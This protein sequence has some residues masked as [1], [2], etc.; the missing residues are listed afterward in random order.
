MASNE[1]NLFAYQ[2]LHA[3]LY[4]FCVIIIKRTQLE[5]MRSLYISL[6]FVVTGLLS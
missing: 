1:L 4:L 2:S 6:K 5:K 3:I